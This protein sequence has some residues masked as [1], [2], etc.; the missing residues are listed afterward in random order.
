MLVESQRQVDSVTGIQ[1]SCWTLNRDIILF[2]E[3]HMPTLHEVIN[4]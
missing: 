2:P 3:F 4:K 1:S